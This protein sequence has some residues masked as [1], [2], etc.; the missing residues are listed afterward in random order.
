MYNIN[1]DGSPP[2]ETINCLVENN[3]HLSYHSVQSSEFYY[4]VKQNNVF[5]LYS[6]TKSF[7]EKS[8]LK[9]WNYIAYLDSLSPKL[10]ILQSTWEYLSNTLDAPTLN[11]F[12]N[13]VYS[14]RSKRSVVSALFSDDSEY[15]DRVASLTNKNLDTINKL[16]DHESHS[17]Q[18]MEGLGSVVTYLQVFETYLCLISLFYKPTFWSLSTIQHLNITHGSCLMTL[19]RIHGPLVL[20]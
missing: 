10:N 15:I 8:L 9:T 1:F 2:T 5:K 14:N 18:Y 16:I 20:F 17:I 19:Y 13:T 3:R 4:I 7:A 11:I 12:N 6:Q